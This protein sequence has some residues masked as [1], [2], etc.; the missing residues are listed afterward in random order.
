MWNDGVIAIAL[1][2]GG[3]SWTIALR[4]FL[5]TAKDKNLW[6][7]LRAAKDPTTA[8]VIFEDSAALAGLDM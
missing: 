2:A 8:T 1:T 4:E 5:P 7:A 6:Q 3:T